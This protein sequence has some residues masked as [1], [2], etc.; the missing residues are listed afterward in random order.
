MA[1][2]ERLEKY[3]V[4]AF[5]RHWS[6][7]LKKLERTKDP[8]ALKLYYYFE[9]DTEARQLTLAERF[10]GPSHATKMA[11]L[12][13]GSILKRI[14]CYLPRAIE[15][16]LQEYEDESREQRDFIKKIVSHEYVIFSSSQCQTVEEYD[17][18]WEGLW[19]APY[20][21]RAAY[22]D[23][24]ERS[25][26][27][28]Y[29][30]SG[31]FLLMKSTG[32]NFSKRETD[33]LRRSIIKNIDDEDIDRTLWWFEMD[34]LEKNKVW[35]MIYELENDEYVDDILDIVGGMLSAQQ[36]D[37]ADRILSYLSEDPDNRRL[38]KIFKKHQSMK[39]NSSYD[40]IASFLQATKDEAIIRD[41]EDIACK[42]V[43]LRD[44][45]YHRVYYS[46]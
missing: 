34:L 29:F 12:D 11:N 26:G 39:D 23:W 20:P 25:V 19:V 6:G 7:V 35:I 24:Y 32:E 17:E 27:S 31:T 33:W 9:A 13:D 3:A 41:V 45:D 42:I 44:R 40:S 16:A 8:Y 36:D 30:V 15:Y 38:L 28:S 43:G 21:E 37:L 4:K 46:A 22:D 2:Y 18:N 10:Y 1:E 5:K 14:S